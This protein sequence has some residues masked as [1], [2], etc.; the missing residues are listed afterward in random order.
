MSGLPVPSV[1]GAQH[2]KA[3]G[4]YQLAK[5]RR[6]L[7]LLFSL[8]LFTA[9]YVLDIGPL[10]GER[11]SSYHAAQKHKIPSWTELG[12]LTPIE[13]GAEELSSQPLTSLGL[14]ADRAFHL[15]STS[16][17]IYKAELEQFVA[18]A[19]PKWLRNRAQ[20]SIDLYLGDAASP[21]TP[22]EIPHRIYQTAKRE[23][24][25]NWLTSSWRGI[26]GYTHFFFDD[27][28][29]NKWVGEVFNG[30]EIG[31]VWDI[32]G[33]GIKE[34]EADRKGR[35][36]RSDLLRY[37]L[38]MVEGGIYTD[39][40]TKRLKDISQ[41][42]Q[43]ADIR[44]AES[45]GLPSVV[46]GIEADVGTRS[47]W[48]QWWPRPLQM[49]QWTFAAAPLHPIL[50]D[51]VRRIHHVTAVVQAHKNETTSG[52]EA[53]KIAH[54]VGGELLREDGTVSIMEWTGILHRNTE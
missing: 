8:V 34:I 9:F 7:S 13:S 22:P 14:E 38:V 15:G 39:I 2:G 35:T 25:W 3:L 11:W 36:K 53:K 17:P 1:A 44:G 4:V 21:L 54:W 5:S 6:G 20:A 46:V 42:G 43:G 52:K 51:T 23:P 47:D 27:D 41:W 29:A 37:L 28:K 49:V 48:H 24:G 33:P 45:T 12:S 16:K 32:L 18:R 19:F 10:L 30:T 40:D 50:I 31:L 26:E